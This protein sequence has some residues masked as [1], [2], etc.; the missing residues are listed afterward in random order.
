MSGP[1]PDASVE[2]KPEP[3]AAQVA[4]RL[5][6]MLGRPQLPALCIEQLG[7]CLARHRDA[8]RAERERKN[9]AAAGNVEV[10][11]AR[12]C[13]TLEELVALDSGIDADSLR[14]LRPHAKAF[15]VAGRDR[16]AQLMNTPR[17][18]P[19]EE[20]LRQTCPVLRHIFQ[21]HADTGARTRSNL[22]RFAFEAL[23][24]AEIELPN[25]DATRLDRL[26]SYL[27]APR[28]R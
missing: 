9:K 17:A 8:A 4:R 24:A 23:R 11:I 10:A 1:R 3:L 16:I 19:H 21:Q 14:I 27:D 25:I 5:A 26:D 12:A 18:F 7:E 28:Q 13:K 20:L 22:R 6:A 15:I 2:P